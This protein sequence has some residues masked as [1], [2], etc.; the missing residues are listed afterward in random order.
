MRRRLLSGYIS[1]VPLDDR[2]QQVT[3]SGSHTLSLNSFK[4]KTYDEALLF[5]TFNVNKFSYQSIEEVDPVDLAT[6]LGSAGGMWGESQ[7]A[8]PVQ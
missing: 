3:I 8:I 5:V 2:W 1:T 4:D 6:L 7:N